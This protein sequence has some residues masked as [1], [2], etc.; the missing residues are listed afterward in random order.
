MLLVVRLAHLEAPVTRT[1]PSPEDARLLA[2]LEQAFRAHAGADQR[3]DAAEFQRAVGLRSPY[4]SGR[5]FAAFDANRD[6]Y[7]GREEF[8]EMAR[9]L[10]SGSTSEKL[11]FAFRVHDHDGDGFI[12]EQ[13]MLRMIAIG[14]AESELVERRTQPAEQLTR[15][16]F[17]AVDANRDGRISFAEFEAA[18]QQRPA[19]LR[20]MTASEAI[21][22][23]PNEDLLAR[24]EQRTNVSRARW[25]EQGFATVALAVV[26]F[27]ANLALLL[28]PLLAGI[29]PGVRFWM[30]LGRLLGR[31]LDF[32]GALILVPM[33]RRLLTRVRA[34][35]LGKVLPV[36]AAVD[37]HRYLGHAL[38]ALAVAHAT[39]FSLAYAGG[40]AE[41]SLI[42]LLATARGLTGFL[43]LAV[44]AV[45]WVFALGFVR[46]TQRF[47]LFYFSH[48]LY[49][50]WLALAIA[51]APSFAF[52]V[53]VPLVGLLV[54]QAQRFV[55]RAP[56]QRIVASEPLRSSVT[57][58]EIE[59]P[60]GF[61]FSAADYVFLRIPAVSKREWHP[62]TL[63]S[64]PERDHLVVH[65]RSLGNWT[66]R[67]R[68][69]VEK[70]PNAPLTAYVDGPYGT[71]SARIFAAR[72]AVLIG[73]GIGVTPFASVLESI[74]LRGNGKS[75]RASSLEKA[76]FFWLNR[77]Q[78]SF[79]WFSELLAALERQDARGLLEFHLCM[80]GARAGS[81][82][83][84]LELARNV[85]HASG[86]SDM[87]TGL[88]THTHVGHPDWDALLGE[89]ANRD[90]SAP[91]DV[92]FCGPAGLGAKIAPV[93][94]R[95]GWR[96]HEERF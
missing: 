85:L 21:W 51:H 3:I 95:L 91:V 20:Q 81:T 50:A 74:V 24:L 87:I 5:V 40:H 34:S 27:A 23:A 57:R 29:A 93:C 64:A 60:A 92:F 86:R 48:L 62:F 8:V 7:L 25:R 4:L 71:P 45:M 83:L 79:E 11:A 16:L 61:D 63:S 80:T 58:L 41:S 18:L 35:A 75:T 44:F 90:G 32:N 59:R 66:R 94:H 42:L 31:L 14:L 68:E 9:R 2:R 47:E 54:E 70:Q 53:G 12:E 43:L 67:L 56:A 38:F 46:R 49:V 89:I 73:G 19:L 17:H 28:P 77:D 6:G 10:V 15:A 65:V 22:I 30:Q 52:W 88:R 26:W 36:D 84:G 13:E 69:L 55:R 82:A 33:L 76:Y 39:C 37:Y 72:R 96:F 1:L 78:Y